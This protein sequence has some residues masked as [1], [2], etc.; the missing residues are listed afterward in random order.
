MKCFILA[1][2]PLDS[3]SKIRIKPLKYGL[4][5][6]SLYTLPYAGKPE[7]VDSEGAKYCIT[8]T[9]QY[10]KYLQLSNY[11]SI[12][13]CNVS[14]NRYFTSAFLREWA[15]EKNYFNPNHGSYQERY[16][17]RAE[18]SKQQERKVS[19]LSKRKTICLPHTLIRKNQEKQRDAR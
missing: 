14:M 10:T 19:L 13:G 15:L 2:E 11:N 17:K 16:S 8:G 1:E 7:S 18:R 5:Y 9:D 4:L 3:N 12:Q 6:G